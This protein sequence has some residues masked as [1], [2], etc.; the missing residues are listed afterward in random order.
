[1][2]K[3][4]GSDHM[5]GH[6]SMPTID[7][8]YRPASYWDPADART[9]VLQNIKGQN[10]REVV[11]R[12]LDGTARAADLDE[13]ILADTL[14]PSDRA[15]LGALHPSWMGGEYLPDYLPGE[16]EIARIVHASATQD[17]VSVR[18]RRRGKGRR[19]LYRVVDE[20]ETSIAF[21]PRSSA[22]PITLA[23]LVALIDSIDL[24]GDGGE[25]ETYVERTLAG[26]AGRSLDEIVA[27]VTVESLFY[28]ALQAHYGEV[29]ERVA[30]GVLEDRE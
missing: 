6:T 4:D 27:F 3:G 24:G 20:Y 15:A 21:A 1:M 13:E 10:R 7:R 11:A 25:G 5:K 23:R 29:A 2:C 14:E 12:H 8:A 19:I 9:A 30:R 16:V 17:V 26:M 28:P 22:Q 18:A